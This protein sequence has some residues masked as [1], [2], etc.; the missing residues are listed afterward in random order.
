M[1]NSLTPEIR[2]NVIR[3]KKIGWSD[4]DISKALKVSVSTVQL[5]LE[6]DPREK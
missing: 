5:I 2:D 1:E 4:N 6:M 3:L